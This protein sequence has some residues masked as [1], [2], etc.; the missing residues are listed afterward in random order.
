MDNLIKYYKLCG[1]ALVE[2]APTPII[3]QL[4]N[5]AID[6]IFTTKQVK[7]YIKHNSTGVTLN[8]NIVGSGQTPDHAA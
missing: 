3:N 5:D 6:T 7:L 1:I 8:E 2:N 4:S